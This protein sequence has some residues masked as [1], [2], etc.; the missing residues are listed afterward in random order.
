MM[1]LQKSIEVRGR[2]I[3]VREFSAETVY[4]LLEW[5]EHN[6]NLKAHELLLHKTELLQMLGDS[7][8]PADGQPLNADAMGFGALMQIVDGLQEVN[9]AFLALLLT[10][11]RMPAAG[12]A[13]NPSN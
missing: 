13:A 12:E 2:N 11:G 8:E 5:M 6:P 10:T 4:L 3:V 7:V 9:Q 1:R